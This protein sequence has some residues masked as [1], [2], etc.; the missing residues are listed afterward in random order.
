MRNYLVR[1]GAHASGWSVGARADLSGVASQAAARVP[2]RHAKAC[3]TLLLAASCA[4]AQ[5]QNFDNVEVHSIPA[6]G[7]VYMLVGAGGNVTAQVGKDGVLLVDTMYAP[8]ASKIL[9]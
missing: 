8:L 3:A 6:Q 7:N 1:F 5:P 2:L 4:F 9:A